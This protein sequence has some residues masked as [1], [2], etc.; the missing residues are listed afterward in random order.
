MLLGAGSMFAQHVPEKTAREQAWTFLNQQARKSLAGKK[1]S[2][3]EPSLQLANNQQ[4]IYVYNDEA[5]GGYVV[6][7]G[8]E[9]M[10]AVL[11]YSLK[12]RFVADSIPCNMR[13]WLDM[14]AA[15]VAYLQSHPEAKVEP[16]DTVRGDAIGPMLDCT[17]GQGEPYNNQCPKYRSQYTATGCVATAMAQIL[18]YHRWPKQTSDVIPGYK[19]R[20]Y[21]ITVPD[22]PATRIDWENMLPDYRN[23]NYTTA[24]VN[25]VA[26][27]MKLCGVA[28]KMDYGPNNSGSSLS[29]DKLCLYFDYDEQCESFDRY[30]SGMSQTEWNQMVYDELA[31]GRPVYYSGATS[32]YSGHAFVI[33]GYE[34]NN[35]FHVN[36]G[37][38]GSGNGAYLLSNLLDYNAGQTCIIGICPVSTEEPRPYAVLKN[39]VLTF[40][41]DQE[42]SSRSGQVFHTMKGRPWNE[43]GSKITK[44]VFDPTFAGYAAKSYD[45]FFYGCDKVTSIE[46]LGYL[47]TSSAEDLSYMFA[48]CSSL[49]E[50][51]LS[52]FQTGNAKIIR[53]MFFDCSSLTSLDLSSFD[54]RNV[55]NMESMF[56]HCASLQTLDISHFDTR[57]VSNMLGLFS[58][59]KSIKSLD[60][61]SL[62][63]DSVTSMQSLFSDCSSLSSLDVSGFNTERVKDMYSMFEGCSSLPVLDLGSFKTGHLKDMGN[64]FREC[65]SLKTIYAT[66][67]WCLDSLEH[68][69]YDVF[70]SCLNIVGGKG[71]SYRMTQSVYDNPYM[72]DRASSY[73]AHIDEGPEQPG[74]FTSKEE[75]LKAY[76]EGLLAY[77]RYDSLVKADSLALSE[78][79]LLQKTQNG[80]LADSLLLA[81]DHLK[82]LIAQSKLDDEHQSALGQQLSGL[83]DDVNQLKTE[84]AGYSISTDSLQKYEEPMAAFLEQLTAFGDSIRNITMTGEE[85]D[86]VVTAFQEVVSNVQSSCLNPMETLYAEKVSVSMRLMAIAG[87][88]NDC[89][90]RLEDLSKEILFVVSGIKPVEESSES[91]S[92]YTLDGRRRAVKVKP[93]QPRG[94]YILRGKKYVVN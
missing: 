37:W 83:A 94:V 33:D 62:V 9:R 54:T 14:Y 64:M 13:A 87:L 79:V 48:K 19:T 22:T 4:E 11:G 17:W 29:L 69:S 8:D 57:K 31:L 32:S 92:V 44:V 25:A 61:S 89:Q 90:A 49:K 21:K 6:V 28:V 46:G 45:S 43:Y 18:Y 50:I 15:Q 41:Y 1:R 93:S 38:G 52:G 55:V 26:T 65:S 72:I 68:H 30:G 66:E 20:T 34:G 86:S 63:T 80:H 59:C 3:R 7:S 36:W 60:L 23:S 51:D 85:L 81:L 53:G 10:P 2:F 16:A 12:G 24:Q 67:A 35:Y 76:E 84:N 58:G 78:E 91:V 70:S 88:L 5:N 27:L 73:Y 47:N 74:Y 56:Y 40:Y 71:S 75:V 82:T 42:K 39:G 77:A